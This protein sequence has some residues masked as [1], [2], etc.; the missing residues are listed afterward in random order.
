MSDKLYLAIGEEAARGT[1]EASTVGFLPL[2]EPSIPDLEYDDQKREEFRGE[3]AALGE[4]QVRRLGRKWASS[5]IFPFYTEA[6]TV[7]GM[8]GTILKHGFGTV[9]SAQNATTGQ[10]L[11]MFYPVCNPF[12]AANLA[13]KALTA[14]VNLNE[15]LNEG[16]V[17]KNWPYVGARVKTITF[18]IE[19]SSQVKM[20]VEFMGQF[21]DTVTAEIGSPVFPAENLRCDYNNLTCYTGTITRTG[22]PPDYTDFAFGSAD[23]FQPD[24]VTITIDFAREDK[25]RLSG[26]DYPDNTTAGKV[27]VT[28]EMTIDW[29]DPAS[30]FSSVDEVNDGIGSVSETNLFFH[31]DTGTQAGTGDNHQ[32]YIDLPRVV[33]VPNG[34]PEY[35]READ[36]IV[37]LS[38]EGLFDAATAE[39]IAGIMLKNTASAV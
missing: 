8:V 18:N 2:A 19:P 38:Y 28:V 29:E 5:F 6:G 22:T 35:A 10:Y 25:M 39:Y 12:A 24:N 3:L 9:T 33:R 36:S 23:S 11:H 14:N 27:M 31:F 21:R 30:G 32:L 37:T 13:D 1:K 15:G 17:M 20:T 4:T 16:A 34:K 26:V 7:A